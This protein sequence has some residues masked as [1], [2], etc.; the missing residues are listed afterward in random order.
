MSIN[1]SVLLALLAVA[2]LLSSGC[3]SLL[4][5]DP[6]DVVVVGIEPLPGEGLEFRM[7]VKLRIQNPNETA[8][9]FNGVSVQMDVQGNRFASGVSDTAG[10]IPRFGETLIK[11]PMS[12]SAL[13]IA[14]QAIDAMNNE[15]SGKIMY[16]LSGKLYGPSLRGV[17]FE[18]QGEMLLPTELR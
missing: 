10:S 2:M 1:R 6:V 8:L 5:R 15:Y 14:R 4:G 7:L 17:R 9:E 12:I 18:S 3:T 11:V 13:R 16:E